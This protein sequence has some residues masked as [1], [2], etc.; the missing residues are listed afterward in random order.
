MLSKMMINLLRIIESYLNKLCFC[1]YKMKEHDG[2]MNMNVPTLMCVCCVIHIN[3]MLRPQ[4]AG[5]WLFHR[6]TKN[7]HAYAC[8]PEIRF[9][10]A[11][12]SV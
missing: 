7:L 9:P 5:S 4:L 3:A 8:P 1:I 6:R 11:F 10:L 2:W 12:D